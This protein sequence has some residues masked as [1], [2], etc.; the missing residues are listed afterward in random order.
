MCAR[1]VPFCAW[2][3]PIDGRKATAL[4]RMAYGAGRKAYCR[5]KV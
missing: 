5:V 2:D 1:V 3:V 4:R